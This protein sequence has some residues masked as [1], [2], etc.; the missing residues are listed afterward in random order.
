MAALFVLVKGAEQSVKKWANDLGAIWLPQYKNGKKVTYGEGKD[1]TVNMMQ[2][3][4]RPI[5]LY[6][7]GYY[8]ENQDEVLNNSAIT[9]YVTKR[10]P[11]LKF[12]S[13]MLRKFLKLKECPR[14]KAKNPLMQPNQVNKAVAVVPI[15]I[16]DDLISEDGME[17]L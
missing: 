2:V 13:K 7:I 11:K 3:S 17:Q 1:K 9:E 15:G 5:H 8:K 14:P 6:E 16:K 4:V 12:M 10:Y